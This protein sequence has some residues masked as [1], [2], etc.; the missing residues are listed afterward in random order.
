MTGIKVAL[1]D[2]ANPARPS[3]R[4]ALTLGAAGSASALDSSRHGLNMLQVGN[5]ARVALP[6]LLTR[7]PL[8]SWQHGLQR[9]EVDTSARSLKALALAG[10]SNTQG[11]PALWLERSAQIGDT[12]YYLNDGSL[13][14]Y[15]W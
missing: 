15:A 3:Q 5:V 4:A 10:A 2:V 6:V 1:F 9:L 13:A 7:T 12:L 14:S 11:Y 8:G